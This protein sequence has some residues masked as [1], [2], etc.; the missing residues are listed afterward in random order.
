[1]P[2]IAAVITSLMGRRLG[3]F[4]RRLSIIVQAWKGVIDRVDR[5]N[6]N[7]LVAENLDVIRLSACSIL[8]ACASTHRAC[9]VI[10]RQIR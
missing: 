10:Y 7:A 9:R 2:P 6:Q 8:R 4:T 3:T 1:M 5:A